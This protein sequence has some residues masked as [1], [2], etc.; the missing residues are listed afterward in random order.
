MLKGVIRVFANVGRVDHQTT[1]FSCLSVKL[2]SRALITRFIL[3]VWIGFII[4]T[5]SF[6]VKT[7]QSFDANA[8]DLA[9]VAVADLRIPAAA[10]YPQFLLME[11]FE[12]VVVRSKQL[13]QII[14]RCIRGCWRLF[15]V[16]EERVCFFLLVGHVFGCFG[17]TLFVI[18]CSCENW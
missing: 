7:W 16:H 14:R 5:S 13:F 15:P 4:T 6:F 17:S 3:A 12:G 2:F 8:L 11:Q 9:I 10:L 1:W 18:S